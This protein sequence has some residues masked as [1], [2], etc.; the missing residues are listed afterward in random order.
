MKIVPGIAKQRSLLAIL[1]LWV[2][3][4][5]TD[6]NSAK[7]VAYFQNIPDSADVV[8]RIRHSQFI[9]PV[10][11]K[12]DIL[13]ID[14]T[15][16]DAEF[17]GISREKQTNMESSDPR[18]SGYMVDKNG[19]VEVPILG[20]ISVV[21]LTTIEV[22]ELVRKNAL[23]YYKDPLVNVHIVNFYITVLGEVRNP[24]RFIVNSEK[25][26]ILDAIGLAGDLKITGKRGNV[27]LMREEN[28]ETVF[29]R[30]D[31]NNTDIFE[32]KYFYLQ[33][34]DKIYVEPLKAAAKVGTRDQS[35][36]RVISITLGLVTLAISIITL[37]LRLK[38]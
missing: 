8:K 4:G 17:S 1:L 3:I 28:G 35:G 22:K 23:K 30:I 36:D 14:V 5:F 20:K 27:M 9:E 7:Q 11:N 25:V 37:G 33:S 38:S 2:V 24:G 34:G 26:N 15:T 18:L 16:I 21:G 10:I 6:C 19:F 13:D 12:G 32:S 29:T 31:L